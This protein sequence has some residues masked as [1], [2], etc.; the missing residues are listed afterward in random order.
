M[1]VLVG[2]MQTQYFVFTGIPTISTVNCELSLAM[3]GF[4]KK[5][6]VPET[7]AGTAVVRVDMVAVAIW[8]TPKLMRY[9][10]EKS[11][12]SLHQPTSFS[13]C[14][15]LVIVGVSCTSLHASIGHREVGLG[16]NSANQEKKRDPVKF[17]L[18][19]S[20]GSIDENSYMRTHI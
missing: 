7:P 18:F 19:S 2:S 11:V 20:G 12:Q 9:L 16:S 17:L 15:R 1:A 5:R 8:K 10:L 6:T 4:W 13:P 3:N 14:C